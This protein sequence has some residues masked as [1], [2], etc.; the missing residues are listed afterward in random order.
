MPGAHKGT[1]STVNKLLSNT[2]V[3]DD[4][5]SL[6]LMLEKNAVEFRASEN[7]GRKH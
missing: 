5:L 2:S 7:E 1:K 4:A 3:D 6:T